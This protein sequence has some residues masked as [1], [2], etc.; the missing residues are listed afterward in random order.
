MRESAAA[1]GGPPALE[2]R[3]DRTLGFAPAALVALLLATAIALLVL[4]AAN[5]EFQVDEVEHIHTAYN[6]RDGRLIYRDFAQVHPPLLYVLLYPFVDPGEP[7]SSF[8][9]ARAFSSTVLLS[10]IVLVACCAHWLAGRRAAALAAGLA[11]LQTT[12]IE[13]GIEVRGDGVLALLIML[14]LASE[15]SPRARSEARRFAFQGLMLGL[16]VVVTL[17]AVFP[18]ALFGVHWLATALRQKRFALV[19]GPVAACL[20]P[21]LLTLASTFLLGNLREFVQQSLLDAGSAGLGSRERATFSPVPYLL[22]EG[23]RNLVFFAMALGAAAVELKAAATPGASSP[24]RRFTLGLAVGMFASLWA[25]PFPWPYVH[26]AVL[27]PLAV[28]AASATLRLANGLDARRESRMA[29]WLPG[30]ALLLAALTAVPRLAAKSLPAMSAQLDT[31]RA[32]QRATAPDDRFFDLAGLYFRPDAYPAFAMSADLFRWY[33]FGR[34]PPIPETLRENEAVGII[35]NYRVGW[36]RPHEKEFVSER[37]VRYTGNLLLLGRELT[38]APIGVD[39]EFEALKSK[40]FRFEGAGAIRVDG[41]PF[42]EGPITKGRHRIRVE[43][44]AGPGRLIL[45]SA[46]P[47]AAAAAPVDLY[48]PFD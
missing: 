41:A 31:L 39:F 20:T 24:R 17:K 7:V 4:V 12:L 27:P 43:A 13:R 33:T 35:L 15:L 30:V 23:G 14:A 2:G 6:L 29:R 42:L 48:V 10:T 19:A 16:G 46:P 45:A 34:F 21:L 26:V 18:L 36:L 40:P 38:N 37:F 1:E 28:L 22:H 25:N 32:V 11:L 8:R 44:L 5:R 9:L 3:L 47:D